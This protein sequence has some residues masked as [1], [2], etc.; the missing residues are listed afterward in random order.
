MQENIVVML[1]K[2]EKVFYIQ[3]GSFEPIKKLLISINL[4]LLNLIY[5]LLTLWKMRN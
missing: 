2:P 5:M 1:A 4:S 3:L